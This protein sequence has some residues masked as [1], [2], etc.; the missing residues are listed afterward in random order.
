MNFEVKFGLI[1]YCIFFIFFSS[2]NVKKYECISLSQQF[3]LGFLPVLCRWSYLLG[4]FI[5][6]AW[7]CWCDNIVAATI[8][9]AGAARAVCVCRWYRQRFTQVTI[10]TAIHCII[11][12][13]SEFLAIMQ[14]KI[15][16][17]GFILKRKEI[18]IQSK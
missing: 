7:W 3:L 5:I 14:K 11:F 18:G 8:T 1:H 16:F 12:H 13:Q 9:A 6:I 2:P 15:G 4:M 10:V 17:R